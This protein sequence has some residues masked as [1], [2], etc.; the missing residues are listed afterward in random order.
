MSQIIN[1]NTT[2]GGG[3]VLTLTGNAGGAISPVLGNINI[4][5]AG[6]ANV[7]GAGNTLTITVPAG[8]LPWNEVTNAT[9]DLVA[10]NGYR[11]N[12]ATAITAT[13]PLLAAVDTIIEIVGQGAGLVTIAQNN[14]QKIHFDAQDTTPGVTGS[15]VS[16][17]RYDC[18][19]LHCIVANTE[20]VVT[21]STGNWT[22]N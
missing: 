18:V 1:L 19:S 11:M 12:R 21:F 5:G 15:I 16:T 20:W 13:L 3:G 6:G 22:F 10:E 14:A 17:N 7:S 4:V 2:G 9:V 8:G